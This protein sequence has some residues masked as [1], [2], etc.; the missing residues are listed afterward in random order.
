MARRIVLRN[1]LSGGM[2][3][4]RP[5]DYPTCAAE[6]ARNMSHTPTLSQNIN[7]APRQYPLYCTFGHFA[8]FLS[9][10]PIEW[11][12]QAC[13]ALQ[14]PHICCKT[15]TTHG[16]KHSP[17]SGVAVPL[18]QQP[19]PNHIFGHL[20]RSGSQ[21]RKGLWDRAH[22]DLKIHHIYCFKGITHGKQLHSTERAGQLNMAKITVY[23][24][25]AFFPFRDISVS[26]PNGIQGMVSL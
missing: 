26:A 15:S 22:G 18:Q 7:H 25:I 21:N 5:Y 11:W 16:G 14:L 1:E 24:K 8:T 23:Q 3:H 6:P 13:A 9:Q 19:A 4:A 10:K 12:D 20:G 17:L 2:G